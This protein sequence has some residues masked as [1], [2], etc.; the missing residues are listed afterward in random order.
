LFVYDKK[1]YNAQRMT[2]LNSTYSALAKDYDH[3]LDVQKLSTNVLGIEFKQS[4]GIVYYN[5]QNP[6]NTLQL[7]NL[8]DSNN[9]FSLYRLNDEPIDLSNFEILYG[10]KGINP[11]KYGYS[12]QYHINVNELLS[13]IVN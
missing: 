13:L 8:D 11:E 1:K 12:S 3:M 4:D 5:Y 9:T 10:E 2:D 6:A 7:Q